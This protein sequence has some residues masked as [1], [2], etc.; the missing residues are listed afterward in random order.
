[1]PYARFFSQVKGG[2]WPNDKYASDSKQE[3][4]ESVL[5]VEKRTR[6]S[7]SN[8]KVEHQEDVD[9]DATQWDEVVVVL[10]LDGDVDDDEDNEECVQHSK[11]YPTV[12]HTLQYTLTAPLHRQLLSKARVPSY[13][14][15]ILLATACSD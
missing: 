9:T 7:R 10:G 14:P 2:P 3:I 12:Q 5:D 13:R 1:L 11:Y 4:L 6:L 15:S 8:G